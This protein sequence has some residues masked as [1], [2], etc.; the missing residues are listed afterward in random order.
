MFVVKYFVTIILIHAK[1]SLMF[2]IVDLIT[3]MLIRATGQRLLVTC[4]QNM[5]LLNLTKADQI[6]SKF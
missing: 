1:Y 3:A 6:S 5:Q 4:C 2:V